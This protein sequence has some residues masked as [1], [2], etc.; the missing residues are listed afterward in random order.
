MKLRALV[1]VTLLSSVA[2]AV[3]ACSDEALQ[4][5]CTGIPTGGCPGSDMSTC[6]DPTCAAIYAHSTDCTWT[7]LLKC[8]D[9]LPPTD[10][11]PDAASSDAPREAMV[12]AH[13]A[14]RDGAPM[15]PDG[16]GGGPG[17]EELESPDC[18]LEMA[19]ACGAT[20][21]GCEDL[22]VCSDGGWSLWGFCGDSGT[23]EP[24][25]P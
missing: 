19:Y 5:Y 10:A 25:G 9:Y 14:L 11:G 22:Y 23:I 6:E 2:L 20:C 16:S 15:L 13:L 18:P 24:A 7:F 8:P 17:C 21:C 4:T 1:L 3:L 12:D